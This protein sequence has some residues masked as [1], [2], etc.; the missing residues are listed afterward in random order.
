MTQ[1]VK[2][3]INFVFLEYMSCANNIHIRIRSSENV[4]ATL[5]NTVNTVQHISITVYYSLM[6]YNKVQYRAIQGRT[7]QYREIYS[8]TRQ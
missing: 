1:G 2:N 8:F 6:I 4:F 5:C 3:N 7:M